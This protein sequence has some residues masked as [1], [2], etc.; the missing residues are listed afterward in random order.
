MPTQ[1]QSFPLNGGLNVADEQM[2]LKPGEM[3]DCLNVEVGIAGG[4]SRAGGYERDDRTELPSAAAYRLI[5]L[6]AGGPRPI[7]YGDAIVGGTSG[8]TA[9]VCG[10][11]A[12]TAGGWDDT[13]AEGTVGITQIAGTFQAGEQITIGGIYAFTLTAVDEPASLDDANRD[14]YIRGA[15]NARRALIEAVPGAGPVRAVFFLYGD[16]YAIRDKADNSGGGIYKADP[17]F[18]WTLQAMNLLLPFK[19]GATV[20]KEGDTINGQ[21][22]GATATVARVALTSGYWT[23]GTAKGFLSIRGVTGTFNAAENI[24]EGVTVYAATD[25]ATSTPTL[26]VGGTYEVVTHNFYASYETKRAYIVNGVG[27]AFEFSEDT[28]VPITTGMTD[29]RPEHIAIHKNY[30]FLTF[31]GSV[32]NSGAAEPHAFTVR[33]GANEI[34]IGDYV[35]A[36]YSV[37]NDV[38]G[39]ASRNSIHLLY[40]ASATDWELKKLS[41]TIGAYSRCMIDVPNSTVVLDTNGVQSVAATQSFGD[42]EGASLS[43]RV[44][45][46]LRNMTATPIGMVINR[47]KSQIRIFYADG[48]G[49]FATYAGDKIIG[50][51]KVFYPVTFAFVRNDE[52]ASGNEITLAGGTD[53]Y[54]YRLDSGNSYDGELIPAFI[55]LPFFHYGS[56]ERRKR[57]RKLVA[58]MSSR[59]TIPLQYATEYDYGDPQYISFLPPFDS[60]NGGLYDR[61]TFG[62]FVYDGGFL[63]KINGDI[64]GVSA[65]LAI[66]LYCEDDVSDPW[67]I[68]A[69]HVHFSPL[70]LMR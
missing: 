14:E 11:A 5:T 37:R 40:G 63:T 60:A 30:L 24:R 49:I 28:F 61:D 27:K 43:R 32:Q 18:G 39:I 62:E 35:T 69:M 70:G 38:L 42:F 41:S 55:R 54:V 7:Q 36:I 52:D 21:T 10:Q 67:T 46:L 59:D 33:L 20:I 19:N 47:I 2:K 1:V 8:A 3:A 50:W 34:G 51:S 64:D 12:L 26:P 65:N 25:G 15:A 66:L 17:S 57:W 56:P 53:G 22:S 6:S 44:N 48:S 68:E 29:D 9:T 58:E 23:G 13:T 45:E 16:M 4:Y 31:K